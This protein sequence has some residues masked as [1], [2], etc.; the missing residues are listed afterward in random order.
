MDKGLHMLWSTPLLYDRVGNED[1]SERACQHIFQ[2]YN[3]TTPPSDFGVL[4]ILDDGSDAMN[5]FRNKVVLPAFDTYLWNVLGK[6]LDH[7]KGF[8]VHGWLA[9]HSGEYN[10]ALHNHRG[11]QI[12]AVFYLLAEEQHAGGN[13]VFTDPRQNS[14]RGYDATFIPMFEPTSITPQ[15]GDYVIFPSFL[16]HYVTTYQSNIRIAMPVDLFLYTD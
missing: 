16:Y 14:N 8:K 7:W 12:S 15:S 11:S 1:V 9:G 3:I 2:H 4:N 6:G 13:I 10:L 5:N